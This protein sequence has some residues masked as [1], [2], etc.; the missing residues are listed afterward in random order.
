[1]MRVARP[2]AGLNGKGAVSAVRSRPI[3]V[4]FTWIPR[5]S[6]NHDRQT[7]EIIEI[8]FA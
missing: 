6:W 8:P 1:M 7:D 5:P 4:Q 2:K 3:A